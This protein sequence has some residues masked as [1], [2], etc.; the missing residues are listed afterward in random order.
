MQGRC[1]KLWLLN[2]RYANDTLMHRN[3]KLNFCLEGESTGEKTEAGHALISLENGDGK[4]LI[5]QLFTNLFEPMAEW[6]DGKNKIEHLFFNEKEKPIK[7]TGYV[8]GEFDV[9]G[10][11]R[12]MLGLGITPKIV[13][14]EQQREE[15]T[16]LRVDYIQFVREYSLEDNFDIFEMPLWDEENEE[17]I[18]FSDWKKVIEK[19]YKNDIEYINM[20]N[21]NAYKQLLHSY[22]YTTAAISNMKQLNQKEGSVETYFANGLTN[23]GL[24]YHKIIPSIND[25]LQ[26]T[27]SSKEVS[28]LVTAFLDTVKIAKDLPEMMEISESAEVI[29]EMLSPLKDNLSRGVI[30]E[31]EKEK[32]N[33]KGYAVKQRLEEVQLQKSRELEVTRNQLNSSNAELQSISYEQ[34]NLEY[35]EIAK[36]MNEAEAEL[37]KVTEKISNDVTALD[38][39]WDQRFA[40]TINTHLK[41]FDN[42]IV[43]IDKKEDLKQEL[44]NSLDHKDLM[45]KIKSLRTDMKKRWE[46][47][48]QPSWKNTLTESYAYLFK[49]KSEIAA[50][51]EKKNELMETKGQYLEQKKSLSRSIENHQVKLN[52]VIAKRHGEKVKFSLKEV[53]KRTEQ[54]VLDLQQEKVANEDK[55]KEYQDEYYNLHTQNQVLKDRVSNRSENLKRLT[56]DLQ[57]ATANE[58]KIEEALS[59]Y[60]KENNNEERSKAWYFDKKSKVSEKIGKYQDQLIK[61]KRNLWK[62]ET[63]K[64]LLQEAVEFDV[65]IPNKSLLIVK[66]KIVEQGIYCMLGSELLSNLSAEERKEELR[67]NPL[68][69]H[70]VIVLEDDYASIDFS[71]FK[72]EL[73]GSPVTIMVRQHMKKEKEKL[74][75]TNF[76]S[77]LTPSTYLVKGKGFSLIEDKASWE[78]WKM[79]VEEGIEEV[80]NEISFLQEIVA[81]GEELQE[82]LTRLLVGKVSEELEEDKLRLE[83]SIVQMN[84]DIEENL[85]KMSSMQEKID[86]ITNVIE[87]IRDSLTKENENI[88][89]LQV[90][91]EEC[92][93]N[94]KNA[95]DLDKLLKDEQHLFKK[96]G[97]IK[98]EIG[99]AG[100]RYNIFQDQLKNWETNSGNILS[101]IQKIVLDAVTPKSGGI[102]P[103]DEYE[104]KKPD[105]SVLLDKES[106][107]LLETYE[108]LISKEGSTNIRIEVLNSEI[109]SLTETKNIHLRW[110]NENAGDWE[111]IAAPEE[112]VAEIEEKA[113]QL[114]KSIKK[115]E[116]EINEAK[117]QKARVETRLEHFEAQAK[118][119]QLFIFQQHQK[120]ACYEANLNYE[121]EK[122]ILKEKSEEIK[123]FISECTL[124]INAS[125][126]ILNKIK[127]LLETVL[128]NSEKEVSSYALSEEETALAELDPKTLITNWQQERALVEDNLGKFK[129]NLEKTYHQLVQDIE[130][131]ESISELVKA[132]F[133]NI[134]SEIQ[135]SQFKNAILNIESIVFWAEKEVE[136][137]AESKRQADE[138]IRFFTERCTKRVQDVI[139]SLKVFVNRM[140][141]KNAEEDFLD[142]VRFEKNYKFPKDKEQIQSQIREYCEMTITALIRK[143]QDAEN[144]KERDVE[145]L[146]N[147]SQIMKVVLGRFPKLYI[148][149]P[150]GSRSLLSGKPKEHLYKEWEVVNNGGLRSSSKS[151]GQ[152]IMAHMILISMLQKNSNDDDWTLIVTD[153]LFGAM[154][155]KKLVQP[156]FVALEMLKV[157]WITVMPANAPVE[158]TSNFN[159]VYL[160]KVDYQKGKG[161]LT[162]EVERNERRF[163]K[164]LPIIEDMR[165]YKEKKETM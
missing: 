88:R 118:Q 1:T 99:E 104:V 155:A 11:R 147:I 51:E 46:S 128:V 10:D 67:K 65:W 29:K 45:K 70:S 77:N 53:M 165:T 153:H 86:E 64:D 134:V 126:D 32:L 75:S 30:L 27:D 106:E 90:W 9:G 97:K 140:R 82:S 21:R 112:T 146:I 52:N 105:L 74:G 123:A 60:L 34:D 131:K 58:Q 117:Q 14:R 144:I 7:Y 91:K 152:T 69:P 72:D 160:M 101:R 116:E 157:Q 63:D 57:I 89:D 4:G 54:T 39:L 25:V 121:V 132:P 31:E 95:F 156:L 36:Q 50:L 141:V 130:N 80:Y 159:A 110:L 96:L 133:K 33:R 98:A 28:D 62:R 93:V 102:E 5:L 38:S 115:T 111:G 113:K 16:D 56:Q 164:K 37:F 109:K 42:V 145:P 59:D 124:L 20:N 73:L 108:E 13:N 3:N 40:Q 103:E 17:A 61:C 2:I 49:C 135:N 22:G 151:G 71:A 137:R 127:W 76:L 47:F 119:K 163:L 161:N 114:D 150:D 158:I 129:R 6:K 139:T 68:I 79:E 24:F 12:L 149:I 142:L 78:Y 23:E 143:Y 55:R 85:V 136:K 120:E 26:N 44:E 162:F 148:Y 43:Q 66:K 8:V 48:I 92:A 83:Q 87:S 138:A 35:S 100:A 19:E 94:D 122:E 125:E 41:H 18:S 84:S 81:T 154:S 15:K 107:L